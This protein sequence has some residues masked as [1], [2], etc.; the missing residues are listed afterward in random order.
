MN[1]NLIDLVTK[2]SSKDVTKRGSDG[3]DEENAKKKIKPSEPSKTLPQFAGKGLFQYIY[4]ILMDSTGKTGVKQTNK[5]AS[6]IYD[7]TVKARRTY[8]DKLAIAFKQNCLQNGVTR[9]SSFDKKRNALAKRLSE[10]PNMCTDKEDDWTEPEESHE[11]L[12]K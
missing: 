5:Q 12:F 8:L 4:S 6:E 9:G 7:K 11:S 2:D 3:N 10:I 1:E